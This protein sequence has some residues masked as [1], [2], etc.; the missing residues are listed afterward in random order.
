M[1]D[2]RFIFFSDIHRDEE[3]DAGDFTTN[4]LVFNCT[5]NYYLAGGSTY[6]LLLFVTKGDYHELG[7]ADEGA[8]A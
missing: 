5:L 2:F 8:E 7:M 3:T 4:S 6:T 1:P